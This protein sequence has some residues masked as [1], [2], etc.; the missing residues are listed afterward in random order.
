MGLCAAKS[1]AYEE[2][3][4]P[5]AES[6]D[7]EEQANL[8]DDRVQQLCNGGLK[9]TGVDVLELLGRNDGCITRLT[10]AKK[11]RGIGHASCNE[12]CGKASNDAWVEKLSKALANN[13][14]IAELT[15]GGG[16]QVSS[17][18]VQ[19]LTES[20]KTNESLEKLAMTFG[21]PGIGADGA[22]TLS[23]WLATNSSLTILDLTDNDLHDAGVIAI[24]D[25][26]KGGVLNIKTLALPSNKIGV[27]GVT[28]LANSFDVA[29]RLTSVQLENNN[30]G[31]AGV[32]VLATAL[33]NNNSVTTLMLDSNKIKSEGAVAL[34]KMLETNTCLSRLS[35]ESHTIMHDSD[36]VNDID[37][38]GAL[39]FAEMLKVNKTLRFLN[40]ND[41]GTHPE[42]VEVLA[43]VMNDTNETLLSLKVTPNDHHLIEAACKR[44]MTSHRAAKRWL[45]K[46]THT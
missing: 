38:E 7:E 34:A 4:Y 35:L 45:R 44:N 13:T 21:T 6:E 27:E 16:H 19:Y 31:D 28:A 25:A 2:D 8:D 22:V 10:D 18:G 1:A 12:Q 20:L 42:S 43:K 29:T 15:F 46:A 37:N 17:K 23:K 39:A 40:L 24:S 14:S 30:L 36:K 3:E 26:L 32:T 11:P 5:D 33:G 41:A 9:L